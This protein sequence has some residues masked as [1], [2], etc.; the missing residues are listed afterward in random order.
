MG[1]SDLPDRDDLSRV[2]EFAVS[3]PPPARLGVLS[4]ALVL[5]LTT[6]AAAQQVGTVRGRVLDE[7]RATP[8]RG[9]LVQLVAESGVVARALSGPDGTFVIRFVPGDRFQLRGEMIGREDA[10]TEIF[11][12]R[13]DSA[14]YHDLVLRHGVLELA[15]LDVRGEQRCRVAAEVG[16]AT[17]L[18]WAEARK[19][20]RAESA[21]RE[22][23]KYEFDIV[24]FERRFRSG[25]DQPTVERRDTVTMTRHDPFSSL[26][27]DQLARDGYARAED[28]VTYIYAPN[29][30]ALLSDAFVETHCFR[31]ERS[32]DE[33][34][35]LGLAFEP[36]EDRQETDIEGVLWLDER[37]SELRRLEFRY[38]N[39]PRELVR[40]DYTGAAE[41]QRLPTGGWI[42]RH[43][44]L[45]TPMRAGTRSLIRELGGEVVEVRPGGSAQA[46]SPSR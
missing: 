19:A 6:S 26:A 39:V 36:L 21:T 42:I 1:G 10:V 32:D 15:S 16:R 44:A 24:A 45:R 46:V 30:D 31:L 40:G 17:E 37:T 8:I 35:R 18:V 28:G 27:P 20:L 14:V 38:R 11:S 2:L 43:W 4:A 9:A 34:G 5:L 3:S 33:P 13:A 25:R 41:F 23:A 29:T 7:D 12:L 22:L